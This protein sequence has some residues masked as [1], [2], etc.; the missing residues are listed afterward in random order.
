MPCISYLPWF[1]HSNNILWSIQTVKLLIKQF[2]LPSCYLLSLRSKYS[3]QQCFETP[4]VCILPHSERQQLYTHRK[5]S[6]KMHWILCRLLT[7]LVL[8]VLLSCLHLYVSPVTSNS[9]TYPIE[10]Y[11]GVFLLTLQT[12]KGISSKQSQCFWTRHPICSMERDK[13]YSWGTCCLSITVLY[14]FVC[15][16]SF[17]TFATELTGMKLEKSLL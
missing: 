12:I 1:I 17:Y 15:S 7:L 16:L 3:A 6:V 10:H 14:A 9:W 8:N 5:L 2:P 4:S 13:A 11:R